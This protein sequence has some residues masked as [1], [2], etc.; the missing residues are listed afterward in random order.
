[1]PGYDGT[2]PVGA[3]PFTG[4]GK[5]YCV[6]KMPK[7]EKSTGFAG[8]SGRPVMD[9]PD[10]SDIDKVHLFHRIGKIHYSLQSLNN[11]IDRLKREKNRNV[12]G[13]FFSS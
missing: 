2:G 9:L 12:Q 4:A 3:G 1:M 13:Q 7:G 8:L 6:L 10:F 5:G 11:R